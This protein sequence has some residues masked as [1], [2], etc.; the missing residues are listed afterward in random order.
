MSRPLSLEVLL[1]ISRHE[2]DFHRDIAQRMDFMRF[3]PFL[4]TVRLVIA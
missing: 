4:I 3:S 1:M 2:G